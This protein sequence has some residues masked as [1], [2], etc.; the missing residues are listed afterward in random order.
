MIP[1]YSRA[2]LIGESYHARQLE[3]YE[4][5]WKICK[6]RASTDQFEL[7]RG[8]TLRIISIQSPLTVYC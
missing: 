6:K 2:S 4:A 3:K 1:A 8:V 7:K 5:K